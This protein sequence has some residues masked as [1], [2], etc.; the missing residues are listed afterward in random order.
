MYSNTFQ[1]G[2]NTA[3]E[4]ISASTYKLRNLIDF[5]RSSKVKR[6]VFKKFARTMYEHGERDPP[7]LCHGQGS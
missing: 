1:L 3:L 6:A 5:I 7:Y 4:H 2:V